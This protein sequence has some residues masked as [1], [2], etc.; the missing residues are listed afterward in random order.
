MRAINTLLVD[1]SPDFLDAAERVL[2]R[3]IGVHVI[4]RAASGVEA[5]GTSADAPA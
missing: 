4:G 1:D 2:H 3:A 5:F